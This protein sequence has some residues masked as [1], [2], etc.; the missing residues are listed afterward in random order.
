MAFYKCQKSSGIK[1]V[2]W[3][4]GS[5][6]EIKAMVDAYYAGDL[7]LGDIQ[8]VWHVGDERSVDLAA[9]G[10]WNGSET[11]EAQTVQFVIMNFG[12]K[13]LASDGTTE[14]LAIIGQ[15]DSL[16]T[17]SYMNTTNVNAE[18]WKNSARRSW[19]N[20]VYRSA[21]PQDLGSLIKPHINITSRGSTNH[22][23]TNTTND[24]FALPSEKE[25]MGSSYYSNASAEAGNNQFE[26]YK[27]QSNRKKKTN[28]SYL[29]WWTR[30]PRNN[31]STMFVAFND[32][33][34]TAYSLA[35]ASKGIAPF[36]CI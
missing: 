9:M 16:K 8:S 33:G 12:G 1:L 24:Y 30:S 2:P 15:K 20:N 10:S 34:A 35:G 22:T 32:D 13:I 5:V 25:V 17:A 4:T 31:N 11:H 18:G 28:G 14:M 26:Y 6:E 36:F 21:I 19:C 3:S 27:T 23:S 29:V 7:S